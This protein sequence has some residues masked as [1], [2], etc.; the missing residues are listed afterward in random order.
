MEGRGATPP[1]SPRCQIII[2][3]NTIYETANQTSVPLSRA[4]LEAGVIILLSILLHNA[5]KKI[6]FLRLSQTQ[7]GLS[8]RTL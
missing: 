1:S 4:V 5:R 7:S 6:K 8:A 3:Y 2:L